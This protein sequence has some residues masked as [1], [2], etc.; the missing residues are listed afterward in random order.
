MNNFKLR[1]LGSIGILILLV[2]AG[3]QGS[4]AS[5]PTVPANTQP[6]TANTQPGT[7]NT[8]P[9]PATTPTVPAI[10]ADNTI[11]FAHSTEPRT[12]DPHIS[13][14][15]S[16]LRN[17]INMYEGLVHY[18][19]GTL[20]IEP[21]LAT[22]WVVSADGLTYSFTLRQGVKFQDGTDFN[23]DAV[24][25]SFDR[26]KAIGTAYVIEAYDH[27][28]VIDPT[29]VNIILS[30]PYAP[31]INMVAKI[32]IVS[33]TAVAQNKTDKDPWAGTWFY[34]HADG[35]GP[36]Q[37]V[38]WDHEQQLIMDAFPGYW[39]GWEPGTPQRVIHYIIKEAATQELLLQ[40][41][42]IDFAMNL[43]VDSLPSLKANPQIV[44]EEDNTLVGLYFRM[45]TFK[46][47]LKNILVRQALQ[48]AFDYS[49]FVTMQNGLSRAMDGPLPADI[50]NAK[51]YPQEYNLDKAKALLTQAGYPNGGFELN[52]SLT[53][54]FDVQTSAAE[55]L[56]SA[57]ATLGI[58]L[59]ISELTYAAIVSSWADP[60]TTPDLTG[61]FTYPSYPDPDAFLYSM[62][63]SK[64]FPPAGN[65][66]GRYSNP[67]VD[68]L[69]LQG[70][71]TSDPTMRAQ[72]YGQI[73]D[74]IIAD[75]PDIFVGNPGYLIAYRSRVQNYIY[76]P[77]FHDTIQFHEL[78]LK[79]VQ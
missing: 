48:Y 52:I 76:N 17:A 77:A 56:Q 12:L 51:Q 57:L 31:F 62:Y 33:P 41:G 40:S 78:R 24:K 34:D 65:N 6:V 36:Y 66:P 14:S 7:A 25:L 35:T 38:R 58:K 27:A 46:G 10:T 68:K 22:S 43:G 8:Q 26:Y 1:A 69:I 29:H 61:F 11:V 59:N 74:L 60:A 45:V 2:I 9:V 67:D 73:Q 30:H 21:L 16:I 28:E 44:A 63:D 70:Q 5:T 23:A 75:S 54:G 15:A 37:F 47:P 42:E 39:G 3:C 72:I 53:T 64:F 18:K 79:P 32:W 4:P 49:S 55:L 50:P 13:D 20:V 71:E 19:Y